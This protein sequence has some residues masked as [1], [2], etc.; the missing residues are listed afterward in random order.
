MAEA[1]EER[2]KMGVSIDK[3]GKDKKELE[4]ANARTIEENRY[5]LD[6]LEEMNGTISNA[7]AQILSLNTTLEST[8]KELERLT[9]LAAQTS[10]LEEQ[11][12]AMEREQNELHNQLTSTED[13]ERTAVQRWKGAE[14]IIGTLQEQVD[15]IEREAREERARHAEVVARFE[16]RR[17]VERELENA[18]GR[19]KEQRPQQRLRGTGATVWCR[20]SSG[21]FSRIMQ[22]CSW[23]SSSYERC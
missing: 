16:R 21:I 8:R 9:V 22:I 20:T 17:A 6:Q 11:L 15:C 1:E 23:A 14:R 4:A 7:D 3:L 18:A 13:L 2:R 19:L 10:Q 5:L 12:A